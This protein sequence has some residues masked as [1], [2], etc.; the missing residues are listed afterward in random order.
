MKNYF[1]VASPKA[2]W[3]TLQDLG[4][5]TTPEVPNKS[6]ATAKE[7]VFFSS[8]KKEKKEGRKREKGG[9]RIPIYLKEISE[10]CGQ[11]NCC[12]GEGLS[13]AVVFESVISQGYLLIDYCYHGN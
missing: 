10:N 13:F 7:R 8:R 9:W 5:K 11:L 4:I 1:K 3:S 12:W 2:S 6:R